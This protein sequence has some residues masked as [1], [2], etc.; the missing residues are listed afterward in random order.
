MYSYVI[1]AILHIIIIL[2]IIGLLAFQVQQ[3][4]E[5]KQYTRVDPNLSYLVLFLAVWGAAYHSKVLY[6]YIFPAVSTMAITT[7]PF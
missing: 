6:D 7:V 5:T 1:I 2:P 3:T 4:H